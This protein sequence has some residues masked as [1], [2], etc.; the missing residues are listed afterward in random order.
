M[1]RILIIED[2]PAVLQGLTESLETEHFQIEQARDGVEGSEMGRDS[3]FD[4]IILD[5]LLPE[6]SGE[7]VCR[8]LRAAGVETPI[9]ILSSK[10]EEMDK[11]L[12]LELGADDYMTKPFGIREMVARI[13]ALLR[14]Q[15]T[16][17][18]AINEFS[19]G[20]IE[21]DFRKQELT[22]SGELQKITSKEFEVLRFL[23]E[24]EDRV[25]SRQQLLNEV[26]GY[27]RFPSTRTVDNFILSL[28]K[29]IEDDPANPIH[30]L[31]I[32]TAGYKFVSQAS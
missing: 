13:R 30:I 12:G 15:G 4:L 25:V 6:K 32:H 31:T 16:L 20:D 8:E 26:W 22:K 1:I 14:R 9:L 24:H 10:T 7:D 19:F 2:D 5:L 18:P 17:S 27:E 11:V 21:V 28:R 29:K 23:I 3:R